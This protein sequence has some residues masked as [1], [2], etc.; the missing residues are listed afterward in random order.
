MTDQSE[1]LAKAEDQ[2][3]ADARRRFEG[4]FRW[5]GFLDD[6]IKTEIGPE[7]GV[8]VKDLEA[9]VVEQR[10]SGA[11]DISRRFKQPMAI[12]FS[13]QGETIALSHPKFERED[14]QTGE[15]SS[16]YDLS[17]IHDVNRILGDVVQD[18]IG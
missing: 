10:V 8:A 5:A 16:V 3:I 14:E 13:I 2:L 11:L 4:F 9:S 17:A 7:F 18:Y 12:A 6:T 1:S 15:T